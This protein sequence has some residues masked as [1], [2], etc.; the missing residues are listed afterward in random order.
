[1]IDKEQEIEDIAKILAQDI[2]FCK[3]YKNCTECMHR[4]NTECTYHSSARLLVARGY[5]KADD[6]KKEVA[7]EIFKRLCNN[8][9]CSLEYLKQTAKNYYG[10][11]I[12]DID[13]TIED[14][15]DGFNG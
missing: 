15:D 5:H 8:G 6:I 7:K 3:Q 9:D 12:D 13:Y 4:F 14:D 11:I 2:H 1:M 10:V